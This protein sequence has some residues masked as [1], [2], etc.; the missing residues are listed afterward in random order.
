MPTRSGCGA[1]SPAK[2]RMPRLAPL[3]AP[4]AIGCA[5]T[6]CRRCLLWRR[7]R[8]RCP[9]WQRNTALTQ[10][11]IRARSL[12]TRAGFVHPEPVHTGE[13]L[14]PLGFEY[15]PAVEIG[16]RVETRLA[17]QVGE[18]RKAPDEKIR[19]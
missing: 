13:C 16:E 11:L 3:S 10:S 1:K 4:R 9:R 8:Q 17:G 18:F 15:V 19:R 7:L 12:R 2:C 14:G 5:A 6:K